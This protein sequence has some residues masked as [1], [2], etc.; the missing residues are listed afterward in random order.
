MTTDYLSTTDTNSNN[1]LLFLSIMISDIIFQT[2]YH[3]VFFDTRNRL[4]RAWCKSSNV[5]PFSVK[6]N[7]SGHHYERYKARFDDSVKQAQKATLMSLEERLKKYSFAHR[8]KI[9]GT[10]LC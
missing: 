9:P 6:V 1:N 3:V 5:K 7:I 2:D 4:S 8:L 10:V